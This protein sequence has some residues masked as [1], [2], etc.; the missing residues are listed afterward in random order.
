MKRIFITIIIVVGLGLLGWQVYRK[1]SGSGDKTIS[2]RGNT[3][4]AVEVAPV[5]KA[6]IR[7][8]GHFTGSLIPLSE[9]KVAPKIAGRLEKI[10]VNIGDTIKGGQLVAVLDDEEYLQQVNQAIA[11]LEVAQANFEER[12]N[13]L[14]NAKRELDRTEAL[15]EKKDRIRIGAGCCQI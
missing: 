9:F 8:I 2:R 3:A 10:L 14:E 4:V 7:E 11:E 5:Q 1:A 12:E 6:S 13:A 15:R